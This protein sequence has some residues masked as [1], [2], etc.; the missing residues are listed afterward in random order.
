MAGY[1]NSKDMP[2]HVSGLFALDIYHNPVTSGMIFDTWRCR[3]KLCMS[4]IFTYTWL[5]A[6]EI[7]LYW[8]YQPNKRRDCGYDMSMIAVQGAIDLQFHM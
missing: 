3:V 2:Y 7:I 1:T 5:A 4:C 6:Q 8:Q